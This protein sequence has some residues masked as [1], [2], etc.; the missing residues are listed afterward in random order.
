MSDYPLIDRL[1]DELGYPLLTADNREA[2]STSGTVCLFFSED[3]KRYPEALDVAVVLPELVKAFDNSFTPVV[4][5]RGYDRELQRE[6][7]FR[8]WPALVFLRDGDYLGAIEKI[9]D[10]ADYKD[11]IPAILAGS[12]KRAPGIG[13]PVT[14]EPA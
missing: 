5:A 3:P 13:I 8:Q 11:E 12:G 7:G 6:Y 4:V 1:T 10:W 9:R 14:S 2:L